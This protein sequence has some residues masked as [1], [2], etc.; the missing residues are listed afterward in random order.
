MSCNNYVR[1]TA[2][3]GDIAAIKALFCLARDFMAEQGNPQWRDG[4]PYD[5]VVQNFVNGGNFRI[6]E[7]GGK[8][9][10]VYSVFDSDGEYDDIKGR[11]LSDGGDDERRGRGRAGGGDGKDKNYL[12][13]HTLAVSPLFRGQ[14][15]A[16]AAFKE[17]E[18]EARVSG[19][20]SIR[21]DTHIKNLPMQKLLSSQG[22]TY[23]GT[24][25][26]RGEGAFICFEKVLV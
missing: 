4:Y 19:K 18:E 12:T 7:I 10:A 3:S 1:R 6:L 24:I 26:S 2:V 22:F 11:W 16:K 15:L 17:A 9:A 14:G 21:M 5:D 13:V 20:A 23:C 25:K 8:V